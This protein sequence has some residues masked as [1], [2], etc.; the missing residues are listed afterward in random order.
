[1][2]DGIP[3]AEFI[4]DG[5]GFLRRIFVKK[6]DGNIDGCLFFGH[7]NNQKSHEND[8][9]DHDIHRRVDE[10]ALGEDL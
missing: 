6:C 9:S 4:D 3:G 1:M 2:E 7:E 10:A 5:F 8:D